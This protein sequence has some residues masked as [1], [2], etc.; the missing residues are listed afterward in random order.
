MH[1]AISISGCM[2]LCGIN[3]GHGKTPGLDCNLHAILLGSFGQPL[4]EPGLGT[5]ERKG[6]APPLRSRSPSSPTG[7]K[8][9]GPWFFWTQYSQF[10]TIGLQSYLLGMCLGWVERVQ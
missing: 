10:W 3:F 4:S 7:C 2:F 5:T 1:R 8:A 6:R 9:P